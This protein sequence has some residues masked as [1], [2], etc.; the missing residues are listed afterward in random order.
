M[1]FNIHS[2]EWDR[3]LLDLFHVPISMMPSVRA[4]SEPYG[5]VSGIKEIDGIRI[6]GIA[7]DQQAALFGQRCVTPGM[8]KNTYGTG[9]F[10][11]MHTGSRPVHSRNH[12]LTTIA[13]RIA[14]TTNTRSKAACS[15]PVRRCSGCAT[16]CV[17][18]PRQSRSARGQRA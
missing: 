10:M 16:R 8:A 13:W 5:E 11:L 9:C 14:S 7:G 1:V 15:S 3:E 2:G 4:S 12:L 17:I 6:A 18:R